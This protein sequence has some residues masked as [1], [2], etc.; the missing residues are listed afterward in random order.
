MNWDAITFLLL[1]SEMSLEVYRIYEE[2]SSVSLFLHYIFKNVIHLLSVAS[3]QLIFLLYFLE[4]IVVE[5]N[6]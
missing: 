4:E 5:I 1:F 6:P 3:I 2:Y